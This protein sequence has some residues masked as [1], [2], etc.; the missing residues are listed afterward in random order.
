LPPALVLAC[1][2]QQPCLTAVV[3]GGSANA[4]HS[5]AGAGRQRRA[6][7]AADPHR[8]ARSI[9][10][11]FRPNP[12]GIYIRRRHVLRNPRSTRPARLL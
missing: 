6:A 8:L 9:L 4:G 1:R 10:W 12:F 3:G 11:Q 2:R 7:G 5:P